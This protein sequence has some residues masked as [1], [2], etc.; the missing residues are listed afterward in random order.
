MSRS[1]PVPRTLAPAE[2]LWKRVPTRDAR[3]RRLQD[4]MLLV[5]DLKDLARREQVTRQLH[6]VC[7]QQGVV[8][9]DLNLKLSLLWVSLEQEQGACLRFLDAVRAQLPAARLVASQAEALHGL[10]ARA[11]R[12]QRRLFGLLPPLPEAE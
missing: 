1:I 9:A 3:G 8:F 6:V 11:R 4:F 5:P 12:P 2:P 10:A 7:Q